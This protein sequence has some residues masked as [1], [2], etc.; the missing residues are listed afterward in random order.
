[1]LVSFFVLSFIVLPKAHAQSNGPEEYVDFFGIKVPI[2]TLIRS[3]YTELT[4]KHTEYFKLGARYQ[5][6]TDPAEKQRIWDRAFAMHNELI[7]EIENFALWDGTWANTE[8]NRQLVTE[9]VENLRR[10][11]RYA[12]MEF[13]Y[14][15]NYVGIFGEQF[16]VPPH[17]YDA[18]SLLWP[19][20]DPATQ[21]PPPAGQTGTT[22]Q[23][24]LRVPPAPATSRTPQPPT[25]PRQP[26]ETT[27][28]NMQQAA[29]S[30]EAMNKK[31][32]ELET[33]RFTQSPTPPSPGGA[34]TGYTPTSPTR[35]APAQ[36]PGRKN[37]SGLIGAQDPQQ[38]IYTGISSTGPKQPLL[39]QQTG[40]LIG[41]QDPQQYIYTGISSTGPKQPLL[42]QQTG[43]LIGATDPSAQSTAVTGGV[44]PAMVAAVS[45]AIATQLHGP[46]VYYFAHRGEP[47]EPGQV[48][49]NGF[50][51]AA[52]HY[53]IPDSP[54]P[55]EM[56]AEDLIRK[57][58]RLQKHILE[59][60][61][62]LEKAGFA[63]SEILANLQAL[64]SQTQ[65]H[66]KELHQIALELGLD[67][68]KP[69]PWFTMSS[70]NVTVSVGKDTSSIDTSALPLQP[71]PPAQTSTQAPAKGAAGET[72]GFDRDEVR[73]DLMDRRDDMIEERRESIQ[74]MQEQ[75]MLEE[76]FPAGPEPDI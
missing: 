72:A 1:M 63:D 31:K 10:G 37:I 12:D 30:F 51:D 18:P 67:P 39:S 4:N 22:G 26:S 9:C 69:A 23:V 43:G 76:R 28:A 64:I 8:A 70:Q 14:C 19:E 60:V 53:R 50:D 2:E 21:G 27:L 32:A 57:I 54:S 40:G 55:L 13:I 17:S 52:V 74:E 16:R 56:E 68:S 66:M 6:A 36:P 29:D 44:T 45:T 5:A 25:P 42:S 41:A 38:Y 48:V 65:A 24:L 15:L 11:Q 34:P 75:R 33:Q 3:K 47:S 46:F 62:E 61:Q 58:Q 73:D 71:Q 49:L 35:I 59:E 7:R 20:P